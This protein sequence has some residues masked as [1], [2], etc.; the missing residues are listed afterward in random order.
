[1]TTTLPENNRVKA[2]GYCRFSSDMQREESIDAQMRYIT[3]YAAQYNYEIVEFYCDRA[4][5]GKNTNRP[6]FQRMLEDTSTGKVSDN[7]RPQD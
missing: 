1:M 6:E 7:H 5:S 4:K 2:V 3:G